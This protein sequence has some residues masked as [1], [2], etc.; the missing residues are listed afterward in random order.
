MSINPL[1]LDEARRTL[2]NTPFKAKGYVAKK[3]SAL[4]DIT[5]QTLY[6]IINAGNGKRERKGKPV[7]P[8][9]HS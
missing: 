6:Y 9:Y 2:E 7:K 8:E 1:Y 4:L 3:W 5:P